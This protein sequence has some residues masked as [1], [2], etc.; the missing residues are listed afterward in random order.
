MTTPRQHEKELRM[1]SKVRGQLDRAFK[2]KRR[3]VAVCE[4]VR[5]LVKP[6]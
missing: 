2:D 5:M 3:A 6:R 4:A 1:V